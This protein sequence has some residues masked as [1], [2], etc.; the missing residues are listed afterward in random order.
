MRAAERLLGTALL[1]DS[2]EFIC[3]L[4][5]PEQERDLVQLDMIKATRN[6]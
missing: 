1:T 2:G 5:D 6:K 3:V 4:C